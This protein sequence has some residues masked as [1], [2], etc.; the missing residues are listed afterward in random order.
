MFAEDGG[1]G[2]FY[3]LGDGRI[4]YLS[5]EAEL[6]ICGR[7]FKEFISI[8]TSI[9]HW[10]DALRFI[11]MKDPKE[12]AS[13]WQRFEETFQGV[14][15]QVDTE[16]NNFYEKERQQIRTYFEV[17]YME[18]P[19]LALYNVARTARADVKVAFEGEDVPLF[20]NQKDYPPA[21]LIP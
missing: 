5:S 3:V 9:S 13:A 21:Y 20:H 6:I 16:S 18:E 4:F 10:Q 1:G 2:L 15:S 12:A 17:P 14:Y 8:T 7:N 11:P 19:F